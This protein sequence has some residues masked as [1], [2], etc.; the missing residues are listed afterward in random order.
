MAAVGGDVLQLGGDDL[1]EDAVDLGALG[2]DIGMD[3]GDA[4]LWAIC[5]SLAEPEGG[6]GEFVVEVIGHRQVDRWC[7]G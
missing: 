5:K 4:G 2:G 1:A 3:D 6:L 7:D